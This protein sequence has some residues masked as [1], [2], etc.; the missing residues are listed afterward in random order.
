MTFPTWCVF[1]IWLEPI[2]SKKSENRQEAALRAATTNRLQIPYWCPR[3][4]SNFYYGIRNPVSYPLNDEGIRFELN[5]TI[6]SFC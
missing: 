3:E 1:T 4:E 2:L 5:T 6:P